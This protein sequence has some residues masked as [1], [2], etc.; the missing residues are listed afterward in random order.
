MTGFLSK[1]QDV[2]N[3]LVPNYGS[4]GIHPRGYVNYLDPIMSGRTRFSQRSGI[5][6]PL[7]STQIQ[8]QLSKTAFAGNTTL[9]LDNARLLPWLAPGHYI[10]I[11][12]TEQHEVLDAVL[13]PD[14]TVLVMLNSSILTQHAARQFVQIESFNVSFDTT[15]DGQGSVASTP[16]VV[17]SP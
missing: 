8:A 14:G 7:L 15:S 16:A 3:Q 12:L 6:L 11:E 9:T 10:S 4:V 13:Q 5:P 2:A 1:L 17:T